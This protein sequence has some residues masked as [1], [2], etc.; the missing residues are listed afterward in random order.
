MTIPCPVC[1]ADVE[2]P[3]DAEFGEVVICPS[4]GAEL[5]VVSVDPI[6]LEPFEEEEK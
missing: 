2:V 3:D 6:R 4:C 5:E 1:G